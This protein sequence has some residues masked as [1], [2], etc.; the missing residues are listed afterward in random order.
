MRLRPTSTPK[1]EAQIDTIYPDG[2]GK[3]EVRPEVIFHVPCSIPAEG[4]AQAVCRM[5][6]NMS[7]NKSTELITMNR[8]EF[9]K[10]VLDDN[11]ISMPGCHRGGVAL[12][13]DYIKIKMTKF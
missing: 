5:D 9:L 2:P 1:N 11:S 10:K 8:D 4:S 12:Y 6:W 7:T 13:R 3:S